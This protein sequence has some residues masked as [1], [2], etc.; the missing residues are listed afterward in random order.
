MSQQVIELSVPPENGVAA[1]PPG[2]EMS[3]ENMEHNGIIDQWVRRYKGLNPA[4]LPNGE[5]VA[6]EQVRFATRNASR[7]AFVA[8]RVNDAKNAHRPLAWL[9]CPEGHADFPPISERI[10]RPR[11]WP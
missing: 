2:Y 11:G 4:M 10:R 6:L 7:C 8:L 9:F 1:D 5:A 3:I